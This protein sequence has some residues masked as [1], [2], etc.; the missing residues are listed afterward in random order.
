MVITNLMQDKLFL[1]EYNHKEYSLTL[2]QRE[3]CYVARM[4]TNAEFH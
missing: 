2:R 3:D 1:S 4:N